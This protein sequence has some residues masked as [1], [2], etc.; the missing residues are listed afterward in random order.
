MRTSLCIALYGSHEAK[1]LVLE[2]KLLLHGL[3]VIESGLAEQG[4]N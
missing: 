1:M 2:R 4:I 3:V